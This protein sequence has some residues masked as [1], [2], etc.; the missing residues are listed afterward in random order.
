MI[1]WVFFSSALSL[2]W[3]VLQ[4]PLY[5]IGTTGTLPQLA[6]GV[7]HCTT[8]DALIAGASYLAA[9]FALRSPDW[10]VARP[11]SGGGIALTCGFAYTVYSEWHNV[12]QIGAWAYAPSMQLIFG[13]GI[14]PLLQWIFIPATTLLILR[15]RRVAPSPSKG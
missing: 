10:P 4:L 9:R 5:T 2:V 14:S 1:P 7:L 13:I 3:E 15:A 8:G 6:F 11:W 12:Y